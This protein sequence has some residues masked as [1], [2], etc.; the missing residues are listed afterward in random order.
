MATLPVSI[1]RPLAPGRFPAAAENAYRKFLRGGIADLTPWP[2]EVIYEGPQCKVSRYEM[3]EGMEPTQRTP[4][5]LVPPLAAPA[6]C[7]DLRRGCSMAEHL[8]SLGYRT[9]LVDY[10]RIGF[11]DRELGLEHWVN[12]VIPKA[13]GV[14]LNDAGAD[15]TQMVGWCLG[16]IMGL[17]GV[18]DGRSDVASISL[19]ASP[20]DFAQVRLMAP[21]RRLAELTGGTLGTALYRALGGAPAGL[22]GAGFRLTSIDRYLTRPLVL[23]SRMD[24][25][26]FLAHDEAIESFMGSMIAYPG[27]TFGQ[28]YHRFFRVNDLSEGRLELADRT[29]DLRNVRAPVMAVAG[30]TDVLAPRAAVHHVGNLV[31]NAPD[32][33]LETAPGGHLGVLTGRSA[34][35]TTWR[36]LDEF[37]LEND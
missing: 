9:Y 11:E 19:I 18:A 2:S 26:E 27:R 1:P 17:L 14:T 5:L 21:V 35:R 33:R 34:E 7:F 6:Q 28:L 20:F 8:T 29:I 16:G 4:V 30:T 15:R 25:T 13:A 22:V 10:G 24:D 3:P 36:A 37:L 23:A 31:P 12:S 32:V